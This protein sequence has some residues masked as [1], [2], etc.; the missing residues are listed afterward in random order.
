M[1][2]R[3]IKE[4]LTFAAFRPESDNPRFTW[5]QRFP[6]RRSTI[7]N[8]SRGHVSWCFLNKKGEIE[9]TGEA[10]GEFVEVAGMMADHWH[11]H[12]EDGWIGVSLNNRFIISLEHNLSRKKGWEDELRQ[13]PKSILGTKHDRSKRYALHHNPET[14]ASLLMACDDSMVKT[15]EEAMRSRNLR[16][17]R[18][19]VGL[20][21][22]TANL[23]G[24]IEQDPSLKVQDLI[25][26]TWLDN[27]LCVIRRK[28][29]QWQELRCRSGL[30]PGDET[31]ISQMLRP[32]IENAAPSTRVVLM[33]DARNG[34]FSQHY[35]P[36]FSNLAVSDITEE[37]NLWNI[38]ARN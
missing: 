25:L 7:L 11:S 4:V 33:E 23:L 29:G 38:L 18:I 30:Q 10:D 15:I 32:F 5:Q 16:P 1:E 35:L 27:S 8:I 28:G 20:F 3:D 2:F 12:T 6:K 17:A 36:L 9:D 24:R 14:S 26:V 31:T 13:N 22:M 37:Y 19:C 21:A 34:A